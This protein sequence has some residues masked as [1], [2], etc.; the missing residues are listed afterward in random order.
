VEIPAVPRDAVRIYE[1]YGFDGDESRRETTECRVILA[2]D[3]GP[4]VGMMPAVIH[5]RLKAKKL[6]IGS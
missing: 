1:D 4:E 6:S 5:A 3:S 2:R